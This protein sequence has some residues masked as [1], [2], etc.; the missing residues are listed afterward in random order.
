MSDTSEEEI[1]E[2]SDHNTDSE[3]E[4][5][6]TLKCDEEI[7][8]NRE[9]FLA[10]DKITQWKTRPVVNKFSK[11][12]KKNL[13]TI[14]PAPRPCARNITDERSAFEKMFTDDMIERI[15]ECT[16]SQIEKLR[17]N[18]DRPR[19]AKYITK[20][21]LLAFIGLMYFI[22]MKKENHTHFLELWN[23]DGTGSEI[24][25]TT[26]GC[27]RFLFILN[28]LRFDDKD[29]RTERKKTDKLAAI[30]FI[31]DRFSNNCQ[32][33]YCLGE[34]MTIDEMLI[35]FRGR[36]SFIQYIPNK[37]AKY[38]LKA[39]VLCDGKTFYV[40]NIELYCGKQ[41]E[42]PFQKSN[43]PHDITLRL[44]KSWKGK[45][46]N[47]T[48]DNWYTSYQLAREL[49]SQ[50][51]TMVGTLKK[52]KRELPPD[53]L[54]DKKRPV[55]SSMF[56]F[57]NDMSI[58][59]YVPKKSRAVILL[60]TM[61]SDSSVDD[62]TKKPEIILDY[63]S[64]KGGVDTVDKM[65]STYSVARRTRRWPLAI[66]FQLLNI[67]GINSQILYNANHVENPYKYRRLYLKALAMSL[68]KPHL[69]ERAVMKSLPS[70]IQLFLAKYRRVVEQLDEEPPAKIRKRCSY[71]GRQKNRVTTIT[72]DT[73]HK[74]VCKEHSVTTI[75]CQACNNERN[76][77]EGSE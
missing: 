34:H 15:I 76:N 57:Q 55:R 19:D 48:C 7:G 59:S 51:I 65:C 2:E 12:S 54:P 60:S 61:H 31:F 1:I 70:N 27:N 69:E 53:F 37:P 28:A 64:Y 8:G 56:G 25:R 9:Y 74:S 13:V 26:M 66:F 44:V 67:A 3:Q 24:F 72:C 6:N 17:V 39:F 71:C 16:N 49:L 36:C 46:R 63:N 43:T 33:N 20:N 18:F 10:R 22:G 21:E 68:M 58:V 14:F 32:N 50:K 11:T 42:G 52:N 40:S 4:Y 23:N 38:G 41:P 5:S 73:C 30:R 45:N 77:S 75:T 35:P 47:L 29:S 62:T